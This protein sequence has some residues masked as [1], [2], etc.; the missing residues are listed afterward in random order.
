MITNEQAVELAFKGFKSLYTDAYT[1]APAHWDKIAMVVPSGAREETYGWLGQ[2]P[3]LSEWLGGS[4]TVHSLAAHGFTIENRKFE[5]TVAVQRDDFDD[6]RLGI[7]APMFAEMGHLTK[8]HP[9]ELLFG[10]LGSGF[11]ELGY[12]GQPFFDA[13]HPAVDAQGANVTVSNMQDGND[14]P[15]Y[16]LDTSRAIKPLIWQER[17]K[18]EFQTVNSLTD[19]DVFMT[20]V[21][22]YGIRARVN[23]GFG[24]WQMAYGSKA[25][26]NVANYEQARA[27]MQ[28]FRGDRGRILGTKPTVM[29]VS[30]GHEAAALDILNSALLDNG[31]TNKWAGTAEL[32]VSPHVGV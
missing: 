5:S 23:A 6:D 12:D 22:K 29:V 9:D 1:M 4:R 13:D 10:L 30:P 25:E 18:Y 24:L 20:D 31:G 15:W 32:I 3:Q 11:T 16:L 17:A 7:Y 8:Q 27:A 14:A 2:F 21:Y 19:H 26:L 28:M